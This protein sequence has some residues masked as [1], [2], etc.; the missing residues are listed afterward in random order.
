MDF[1]T[2]AY[3]SRRSPSGGF[4]QTSTVPLPVKYS[5]IQSMSIKKCIST[6]IEHLFSLFRSN[7]VITGMLYSVCRDGLMQIMEKFGYPRKFI[8]LVLQLYV[9]V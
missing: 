8:T 3:I 6:E 5:L 4:F 9:V 1:I 2:T 7:E